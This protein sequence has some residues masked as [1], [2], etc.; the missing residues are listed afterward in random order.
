MQI[1]HADEP[2][3]RQHRHQRS[4]RYGRRWAFGQR[5]ETQQDGEIRI[6]LDMG[7][8]VFADAL[9]HPA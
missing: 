1:E 7:E 5:G 4:G 2:V 9:R 3:V 8:H 6:V